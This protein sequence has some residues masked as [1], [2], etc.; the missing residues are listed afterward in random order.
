MADLTA[1]TGKFTEL[2]AAR[3]EH[4]SIAAI[5]PHEGMRNVLDKKSLRGLRW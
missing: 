2:L 5:E 3:P 4:Y 1:G